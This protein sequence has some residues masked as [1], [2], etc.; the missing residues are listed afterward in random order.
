MDQN[1]TL[2][3]SNIGDAEEKCADIIYLMGMLKDYTDC[4]AQKDKQVTTVGIFSELL[5]EKCKYLKEKLNEIDSCF[6]I[7][8]N[9]H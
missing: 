1:K 6:Y 4:Y 8:S 9:N 7:Y 2:I 5:I 3:M